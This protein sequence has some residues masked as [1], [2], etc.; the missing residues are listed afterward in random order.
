[1]EEVDDLFQ[2]FLSLILASHVGKGD[3]GFLLHI[4]LGISFAY[5]AYT[6]DPAGTHLFKNIAVDKHHSDY[7]DENGQDGLQHDRQHILA[8]G[9]A[10]GT[11]IH[12]RVIQE[13]DKG[14]VRDRGG[15]K[16]DGILQ[17]LLHIAPQ[18]AV[19]QVALLFAE[20]LG[21]FICIFRQ[22]RSSLFHSEIVAIGLHFH[23][24]HIPGFHPLAEFRVPHFNRTGILQGAHTG[25]EQQH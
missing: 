9:D 23:L 17:S 16:G 14:V 7:H 18:Q 3:A 20:G 12:I 21:D 1:M 13:R 10:L 2:A 15:D 24:V 6:A 4:H 5:A 19:E 11:V 25:V 8:V 22:G